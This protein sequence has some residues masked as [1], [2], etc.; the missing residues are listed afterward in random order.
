MKKRIIIISFMLFTTIGIS[1]GFAEGNLPG[2]TSTDKYENGCISCHNGND[3]KLNV[4]MKD[5]ASHPPIDSMI[6]NVPG[7]CS[8]CHSGNALSVVVHKSHYLNPTDNDFVEDYGNCLN[9]HSLDLTSWSM[10][11]KSGIKNW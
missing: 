2:I 11:V 1:F 9:C 8:M 5:I 3:S 6:T 10:T 7:D 4:I